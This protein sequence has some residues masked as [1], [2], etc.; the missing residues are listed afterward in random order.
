MLSQLAQRAA[1]RVFMRRYVHGGRYAVY[2]R[3]RADRQRT[4]AADRRTGFDWTLFQLMLSDEARLA[5]YR[6]DIAAV[7]AGK[8]VLEVGP[9]PEAVLARM[10]LAAGA[11]S[12]LS[13]EGDPWVAEAASRRMRAVAPGAPWRLLSTMS[14]ELTVDDVGHRDVDVLV[15]EVYDS[16]AGMEHVVETVADLRA[17]G[18]TFGSVISR[19]FQTL[20]APARRP[21][22][23]SM[24]G[25]ERLALGW[26]VRAA[27]AGR[28]AA[29]SPATL[30]GRPD[31][32]LGHELAQR[33]PWQSCDLESGL[34]CRTEPELRFSV[35]DLARVDGVLFS[36]RFLFHTG[37]L[38][39]AATPTHWGVYFQP[40][41]LE[42]P[43]TGPGVVTVS[44]DVPD[45]GQPSRWTLRATSVAGR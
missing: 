1:G 21:A 17:R 29:T 45:P 10:C 22:P 38:D 5:A 8:R 32:V 43:A 36:N 11:A 14:T 34:P 31:Q 35:P 23:E 15:L 16:I 44:T 7:V 33:Q 40:L 27:A 19:G 13:V 37:E 20:V 24:S 30:H 12:V 26:P 28:R 3:T 9:G 18:F 41:P 4:L 6:R 42:G 2:D 25:V 39:T